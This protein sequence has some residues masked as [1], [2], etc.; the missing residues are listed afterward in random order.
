[1]VLRRVGFDGG[2]KASASPAW[3]RLGSSLFPDDPGAWFGFLAA[4]SVGN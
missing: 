3:F 1:M 2:R 4:D